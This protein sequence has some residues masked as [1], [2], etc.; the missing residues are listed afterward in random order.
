MKS[1]TSTFILYI[2]FLCLSFSN[3]KTSKKSEVEDL[4]HFSAF[5]CSV[6]LDVLEGNYSEPITYHE[7][8]IKSAVANNEDPF[9]YGLAFE[10]GGDESP[11]LF[12]FDSKNMS[13][14]L[15]HK[16]SGAK[17]PF[18]IDNKT[19]II[20]F[21]GATNSKGKIICL[22]DKHFRILE[23]FDDGRQFITEYIKE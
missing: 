9:D 6:N 1:K 7:S 19:S 17:T 18:T 14:K 22:D 16:S 5:G 13:G 12:I 23:A 21:G 11:Y 10:T 15:E 20:S 2:L 8:D 4:G 3:C